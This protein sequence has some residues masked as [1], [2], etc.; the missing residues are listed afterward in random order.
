MENRE[1]FFKRIEPHFSRKSLL[2]IQ[3]AYTLSKYWH[4]S[5]TRKELA[6][7][8]EP[9]RYFEHVRRVSLILIDEAKCLR[10]EMVMASL[11]HD[12][13]EDTR[14]EDLSADMIEENFGE[15][16]VILVKTL[17]K[18][19]K[20]GYLER[21][22]MSTDWRPYLIKACDRLDNLRSL[23]NPGTTREFVQKQLEETET[24][25][26]P[27]FDHMMR[28]VPKEYH[29]GALSVNYKIRNAVAAVTNR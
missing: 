22:Y 26:Y 14:D 20:E 28:I 21:F 25:Y 4:R 13:I 9:L 2:K 10:P 6:E 27:L 19:P 5:Q 12:A 18:V 15:D 11:L 23:I 7:N 17:S 24:K 8:G 3:L 16:V 1:T 29:D